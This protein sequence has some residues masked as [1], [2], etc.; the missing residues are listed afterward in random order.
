MTT[1]RQAGQDDLATITT[2]LN[3]FGFS[4]DSKSYDEFY[5]AEDNSSPIGIIQYEAYPDFYFLSSLGVI[6]QNQGHNIGSQLINKVV[7][8]NDKNIYLFTIIPE[9]FKKFG[10]SHIPNPPSH[11]LNLK[12]PKECVECQPDKCVCMVKRKE[13]Q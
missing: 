9:F 4:Y 7:N 11:V 6:K 13:K 10:F 12:N 3:Y 1:I 5:L 2:L 8:K